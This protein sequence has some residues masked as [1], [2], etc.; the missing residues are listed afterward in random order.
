MFDVDIVGLE[1][2]S[3]AFLKS[4]ATSVCT[5]ICGMHRESTEA[6]GGKILCEHLPFT[7]DYRGQLLS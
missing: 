3:F 2:I 7:V 4:V 6:F 5:E 1:M